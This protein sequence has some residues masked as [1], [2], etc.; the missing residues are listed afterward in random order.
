[1]GEEKSIPVWLHVLVLCLIAG[2]VLFAV[3]RLMLWNRGK[4]VDLS[5]IDEEAFDVEINDNIFLLGTEDLAGKKDD[6]R[7]TILFL[8]D[9][10]ITWDTGNAGIAGILGKKLSAEVVNAGFSGTTVALKN[11]EYDGEYTADLFSFSALAAEIAGGGDF[12]AQETAAAGNE[13]YE[14]A[15]NALKN[16]DYDALDM[17]VVAYDASDYLNQ[18][19]GMN[20]DNETDPITYKGAMTGGLLAIKKRY[21]HIRLVVLSF[22]LCYGFDPSGEIHSGYILNYGHG[23]ISDYW[24]HLYDACE[25]CGVSFI[26]NLYGTISESESGKYL[27]DNVHINGACAKHIAKHAAEKLR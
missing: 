11:A 18:R 7:N 1:M 8:G 13:E 6:G 19:I 22:P 27:S 2:A 25:R 10:L 17:L 26:D 21:P 12:T 23:R 3:V 16:V 9:D 20:P 5:D 14:R 24:Q 15:V 4:E